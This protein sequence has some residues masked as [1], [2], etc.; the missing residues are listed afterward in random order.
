MGTFSS[1][2]CSVGQPVQM[3][4]QRPQR[5]AVRD[6]QDARP[7]AQS[8]TIA[9]YQYGSSRAVTSFS[10]SVRGRASGGSAA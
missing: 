2:T 8:G 5:V 10:D 9:S 7:G 4:D 3:L 1:A 6:D